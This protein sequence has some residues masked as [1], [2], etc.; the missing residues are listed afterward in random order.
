MHTQGKTCLLTSPADDSA[1]IDAVELCSPL[2]QQDEIGFRIF[3]AKLCQ[4]IA[5]IMLQGMSSRI[6]IL[7]SAHMQ[8]AV[9]KIHLTPPKIGGFRY[10]QTVPIK[11]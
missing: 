10:P 3:L 6:A 4:C 7:Q 11:E 9:R 1:G 8:C 2:G 5:R